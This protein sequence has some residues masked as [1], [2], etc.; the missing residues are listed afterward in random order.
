MRRH[1]PF[2]IS[3][4]SKRRPE[5]QDYTEFHPKLLCELNL[6]SGFSYARR[7]YSCPVCDTMPIDICQDEKNFI[8][9]CCKLPKTIANTFVTL[10]FGDG[11]KFVSATKSG[12]AEDK[13]D[14]ATV[15]KALVDGYQVFDLKFQKRVSLMAIIAPRY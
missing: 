12:G 6:N 14:S 1:L 5:G 7:S 15:R 3:W 13:F 8:Y 9:N 11:R 10:K 2:G 4:V